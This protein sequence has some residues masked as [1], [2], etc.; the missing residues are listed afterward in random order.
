MAK[1]EVKIDDAMDEASLNVAGEALEAVSLMIMIVQ[2]EDRSL[3]IGY[4]Y[5]ESMATRPETFYTRK[6][7]NYLVIRIKQLLFVQLLLNACLSRQGL[8]NIIGDGRVH[9]HVAYFEIPDI[10]PI[11]LLS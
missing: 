10:V 7:C 6:I 9:D 1:K 5:T 11:W 2:L 8:Y 3:N 4:F